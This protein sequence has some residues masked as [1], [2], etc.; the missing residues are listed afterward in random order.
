MIYS[1]SSIQSCNFCWVTR[2]RFHRPG[3]FIHLRWR[4]T[5]LS[6]LGLPTI[7]MRYSYM[8]KLWLCNYIH[9]IKDT[10]MV[11]LYNIVVF[12][13]DSSRLIGMI[14]RFRTVAGSCSLYVQICKCQLNCYILAVLR[15]A[16]GKCQHPEAMAFQY[17]KIYLGDLRVPYLGHPSAGLFQLVISIW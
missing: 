16:S 8:V 11:K 6:L 3:G 15:S 17:K 2:E 7:S 14:W 9:H 5:W 12:I 1:S 13:I 4:W 10:T